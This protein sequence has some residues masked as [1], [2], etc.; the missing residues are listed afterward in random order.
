MHVRVDDREPLDN[1]LPYLRSVEGITV[2]VRRLSVGD[3]DVDDRLIF[4]RKTLSDFAASLVEGRLFKQACR[5]AGVG[6]S[7]IYILEGSCA[8]M[9]TLGVR[10]EAI[11][12]ALITLSVVMNLPILRSLNPLETTRLIGYCAEQVDRIGVNGLPRQGYRPKGKLKR[13]MF[14][15][16]GLPGIGP[17]RARRLLTH[18]G[19]VEKVVTADAKSLAEIDGIGNSMAQRIRWAVA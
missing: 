5:L 10:R 13:Q 3:Y 8:D 11:Q 19:S 14:L 12:G 15:L 18:F 4:E 2:E 7:A 16:Q 1:I 17:E 6:R 9:A